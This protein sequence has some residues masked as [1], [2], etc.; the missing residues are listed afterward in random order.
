MNQRDEVVFIVRMWR[1]AGEGG[2]E[3][4][5]RG[6]IRQVDSDS[7]LYVTGSRDVSDFISARLGEAGDGARRV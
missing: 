5:W 3:R 4:E 7:H 1:Q 6:S 2:S